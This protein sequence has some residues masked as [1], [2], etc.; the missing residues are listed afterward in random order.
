MRKISLVVAIS[1]I[2]SV[3]QAQ[4]Y[5][6]GGETLTN[7]STWLLKDSP[8]ILYGKVVVDTNV[9]LTIEPG[10]TVIFDNMNSK[11]DVKGSLISKGVS[12]QTRFDRTETHRD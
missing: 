5:K 1:L 11:F 8:F 3:A 2:C 4:T 7:N 6:Y 10:S 12:F 9:T